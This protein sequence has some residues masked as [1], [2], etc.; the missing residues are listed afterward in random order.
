MKIIVAS[1][2]KYAHGIVNAAKRLAVVDSALYEI[3]AYED[4]RTI[5]ELFDEVLDEN[6]EEITIILTDLFGGSV[7]QIVM[8][9]LLNENTYVIAGI[10]VYCLLRVLTINENEDIEKQIMEII[11]DSKDQMV[12]VNQ[13]IIEKG[14]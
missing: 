8:N 10:N 2:G 7:N 1:H 13:L 5:N 14:Y 3:C 4:C 11:S 12:N 6:N 9:N